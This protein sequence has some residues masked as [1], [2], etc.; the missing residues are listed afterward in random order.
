MIIFSQTE[1][2]MQNFSYWLSTEV[3][4]NVKMIMATKFSFINLDS[5]HMPVVQRFGKQMLQK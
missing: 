3:N 2:M 1:H 4:I 5:R